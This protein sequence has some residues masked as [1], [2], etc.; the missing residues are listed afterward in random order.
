MRIYTLYRW[1]ATILLIVYLGIRFI[2]PPTWWSELILFN[3]V[4]FAAILSIARSPILDDGLGRLATVIA[5]ASWGLG[6]VTSALDS[7][8]GTEL[9]LYAE[10][11]YCFF[12]PAALFGLVRALRRADKSR[13]LEVLD[14][15]VIALSGTT[16]IASLLL[17]PAS[18]EIVGTSLEV[19]LAITY[20]IGDLLLLLTVMTI[21]IM[22]HVTLRN[23]LI[24]SGVT[25]FAVSDFYYLLQSRSG[26]Y[27]FGSLTDAG[28]LLSFVLIGHA[29]WFRSDETQHPRSFNPAVVTLALVLSALILAI[30]V[31]RPDY[32]PR[33]VLVP[34]FATIALAF[35]RMAVA[36]NDARQ[37]S[38]EQI[39]ARTDELTGLANRRRFLSEFEEFQDH[40]GSLLILDLDGFKPVNDHLGHEVGDQLLAQVARRFERVMPPGALLARLGGDEFGALIPGDA[41]FETALALRA[42]LSYPFHI[43][44]NEISLD[45]SVGEAYN[46]PGRG[47]VNLLRCADEAMYEA[48]RARSGV[49]RYP[50]E[51]RR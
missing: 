10:I 25:A 7:Y 4:V 16:L 48:K 40:T 28:W 18:K 47:E 5:F 35:L 20:P 45:V 3:S 27:Q 29:F 33:F 26:D 42:T 1:L 14:T 13:A 22:D 11:A 32:F 43:A 21:V 30:A 49:S 17:K 6:S 44:G 41:G 51:I 50:F 34:A 23:L 36:M 8:F 46:E 12:Y 2:G 15:L 31:L 39:L 9:S 19:F 24:L 37:M 38:N